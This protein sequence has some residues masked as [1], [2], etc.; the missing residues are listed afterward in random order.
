T[1]GQRIIDERSR[2]EMRRILAEIRDGSFA[3]ELIEEFDA[4]RP[5]FLKRREAEQSEQIEQV[6]AAL[7]PLMSWLETAD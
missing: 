1:R 5:T 3:R 6:G 7:R 4:G 2:A